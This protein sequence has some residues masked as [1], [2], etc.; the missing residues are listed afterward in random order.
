[1]TVTFATNKRR[2]ALFVDGVSRATLL[3]F[4]PLLLGVLTSRNEEDGLESFENLSMWPH[5]CF[6]TTVMVATYMIGRVIGSSYV[7]R[8]RVVKNL[9]SGKNNNKVFTRTA[10]TLVALHFYSYG[11]GFN[12][13][14]GLWL[15]RLTM[16]ILDGLMLRVAS[17]GSPDQKSVEYLTNIVESGIA[18]VWII[19]FAISVLSSGLLYY[20]LR[21][22]SLFSVV[23]IGQT[24]MS[25]I[26]SFAFFCLLVFGI[27]T[28]LDCCLR[29]MPE[30]QCYGSKKEDTERLL[31]EAFDT[32]AV[33]K[34]KN[35][36]S[37]PI[38]NTP[39]TRHRIGSHSRVRLD[40]YNRS[41]TGSSNRVRLDSQRSIT[42]DTF[43]DCESQ[44]GDSFECEYDEK[45]MPHNG[46]MH[47]IA[48]EDAIH[49]HHSNSVA[50]YIDRRCVFDDGSPSSVSV[51]RSPPIIPVAYQNFY[52]SQAHEKWEESK[53]WRKDNKI[54]KIHDRPHRHFFKIKEAYSH[55]VH[56]YSKMGYPVVYEKPGSMKLKELF[57]EGGSVDDMLH[58]YTYFLEYMCNVLSQR[59]EL[60]EARNNRPDSELK[61][62]WGFVV[63]MDTTGFSL[64]ILS[65]SVL[66]YLQKAQKINNSHYP[67][68]TT[69]ALVV[70]SPFWLSSV[71][72]KLKPLLPKNAKTNLF[73]VSNSLEGL[74]EHIDD[75]QIPK[76]YG[77][78]SPYPIGEHPFE[79]QLYDLVELKMDEEDKYETDEDIDDVLVDENEVSMDIPSSYMQ[80][81]VDGNH[82]FE[83]DRDVLDELEAGHTSNV[84]F[85]SSANQP[86]SPVL[87]DNPSYT[88]D[89]DAPSSRHN[90]EEL[91]FL[92][93]SIIHWF[94]C[95]VQGSLEVLISLWF[96]IPNKLGGLGYKPS[97]S[98]ISFFTSAI[99][100]IWLLRS[101]VARRISHIPSS[102]PRRG[103]RIGVGS[104]AVLFILFPF[105]SWVSSND[106]MLVLTFNILLGSLIFIAAVIGRSSSE[107]LHTVTSSAYLDKLSLRCDNRTQLGNMINAVA[108]FVRYGGLTRI[109]GSSGEICGALLVSPILAWS[110]GEEHNYPFNAALGFHVGAFLC[111]MLYMSSFSVKIKEES[112]KTN[113]LDADRC[114]MLGTIMSASASD[115]STLVEVANWSSCAIR[116]RSM[117]SKKSFDRKR[118]L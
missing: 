54:Y 72:G 100:L 4:A 28:S 10:A 61:L 64:S 79:R 22:S 65:G 76:E 7:F 106:S 12:Q 36:Y 43:F 30:E 44:F 33:R 69:L 38:K 90:E 21:Q 56:G 82:S 48:S 93:V 67:L 74:R 6:L 3:P 14:S 84:S 46:T 94:S 117:Q 70:N 86:R 114:T 18:Q 110:I 81:T 15:I 78:S 99:V 113:E 118:N 88:E 34:Q 27:K 101:N 13:T 40:S 105:V 51:G 8:T 55:C 102:F 32:A 91:T 108:N 37:T 57:K 45:C 107:T 1:M 59:P 89:E 31:N 71:F 25:R 20:P 24:S 85:M 50:Q 116:G 92:K 112:S 5:V 62:D 97:M 96:L 87:L 83:C 95:V 77:G 39:Q 103:Y 19:G 63:V 109:L 2:L 104:M 52:K 68:T 42:S 9:Y 23:Q 60:Q 49:K 53:I 41:R 16:G 111:S 115:M 80:Q 73:G 66:Q 75:D 58:H 17:M 11:L 35:I 47:T 26:L 98:G 29:F